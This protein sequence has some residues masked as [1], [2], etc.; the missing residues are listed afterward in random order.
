MSDVWRNQKEGKGGEGRRARGREG[1]DKEN[2]EVED[3][4]KKGG[5]IRSLSRDTVMSLHVGTENQMRSYSIILKN[6]VL[7]Y[8]WKRAHRCFPKIYILS[9]PLLLIR[10]DMSER[11]FGT[12]D[13]GL[14]DSDSLGRY[15]I[16]VE[17]GTTSES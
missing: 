4:E 2:K 12:V 1:R 5:D 14:L 8:I 6:F 15:V 9:W 7:K 16:K 10:Y 13:Y 3:E 11:K 17:N